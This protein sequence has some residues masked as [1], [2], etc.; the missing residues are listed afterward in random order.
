MYTSGS[1][2]QPKGVQMGHR[3]LANLTSWQIAA[4]AMDAETRFLQYAPL[5]FDVSFQEILPTLAAGGTVVSREPADRR[6]FT[7][8]L[9]R[10][11]R[12]R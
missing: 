5:G 11:A 8:M 3:P 4:L 9:T 7:A 10:I 2:G 6:M 12:P 1:T